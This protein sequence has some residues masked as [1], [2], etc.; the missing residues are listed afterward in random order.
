MQV[1][2]TVMGML[3]LPQAL[4]VNGLLDL[5]QIFVFGSILV[6][7]LRHAAKGL[8]PWWDDWVHMPSNVANMS[9]DVTDMRTEVA[10]LLSRAAWISFLDK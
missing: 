2:T 9:S 6:S 1:A 8:A 5:F 7:A 4:T 10:R 3:Q